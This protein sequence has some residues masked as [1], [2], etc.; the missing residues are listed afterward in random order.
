MPI[1]V[2]EAKKYKGYAEDEVKI[3]HFLDK[4]EGDAFTE[5]E[6]RKGIGK[7]DI[8]FVPDEKGSYWTLPNV[9]SFTL[10]VLDNI[11]FR[12]T[13]NEMAKKGKISVSEVSGKKYYFTE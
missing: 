9:G 5:E 13:L 8:A 10:N 1:K 12:Q 7:T 4:N 2:E 6:I 11:F 3:A